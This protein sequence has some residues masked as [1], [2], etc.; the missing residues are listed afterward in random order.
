M[1]A[2]L[3]QHAAAMRTGLSGVPGA[4]KPPGTAAHASPVHVAPPQW[5]LPPEILALWD[6]QPCFICK[7]A[8]V[9]NNRGQCRHR[10]IDVAKAELIAIRGAA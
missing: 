6:M 2:R 9:P 8:G 7:E 5:P 10:E 1:I 3:E 4:R